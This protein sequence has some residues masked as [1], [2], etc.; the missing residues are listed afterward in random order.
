MSK[1]YLLLQPQ[2]ARPIK[3]LTKKPRKRMYVSFTL[4]TTSNDRRKYAWWYMLL[5]MFMLTE[6]RKT[7]STKPINNSK[8][9]HL[10]ESMRKLFIQFLLCLSCEIACCNFW[11]LLVVVC[12]WFSSLHFIC[13]WKWIDARLDIRVVLKKFIRTLQSIK[14][15]FT[16]RL[17]VKYVQIV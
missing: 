6:R 1:N 5:L 10:S 12:D 11:L 7:Q 17:N 9:F 16:T 13:H 4:I 2:L 3:Q 14:R 15:S 8:R